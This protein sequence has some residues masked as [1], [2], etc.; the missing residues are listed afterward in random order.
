MNRGSVGATFTVHD[1]HDREEPWHFTIG[2]GARHATTGFGTVATGYD[3]TVRGPNGFWRRIAAGVEAAA[4]P[5]VDVAPHR[6]GLALTIR[7]TDAAPAAMQVAMDAR[8]PVTGARKRAI[9]VPPVPICR[10]A[11]S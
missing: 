11:R 8:Y 9:I 5:I 4:S 2:A 1:N 3:L 10:I 6:D 7:N